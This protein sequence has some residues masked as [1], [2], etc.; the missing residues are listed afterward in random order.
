MADFKPGQEFSSWM[1]IQPSEVGQAIKSGLMAYGMQKSGLTDWLNS[2]NKKP[3]GSVPPIESG[4]AG[5]MNTNGVWGTNPLPVVP[6]SFG[7]APA[8][9]AAPQAPQVMQEPSAMPTFSPSQIGKDWLDGKISGF[10]NPQAA[11]DIPVAQQMNPIATPVNPAEWQNS[12]TGQGKFEQAMK[13]F[14]AMG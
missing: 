8:A 5:D 7:A 10:T 6:P 4:A 2:L 1:S 11:R 14:A 9:P 3:E 12:S 13:M